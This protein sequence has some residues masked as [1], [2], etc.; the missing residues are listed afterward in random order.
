MEPEIIEGQVVE[1]TKV[2][3]GGALAIAPQQALSIA[4]EPKAVLDEAR[5]AASC[6]MDVMKAK[7]K[8]VVFNGEQYLEYEDWLTVARFY[9]VTAKVV[10]TQFV[11]FG[12]VKGYEARAVALLVSTGMEISGADAMC[13]NDED[14]WSTRKNYKTGEVKPVPMFQLRSMAQTRAC[15]KALR[16]V[17]AWVVVLAG[18]KPT[19]AEEMDG[20]AQT[21][22]EIATPQRKAA[23]QTNAAQ[24]AN[25]AT[26]T[27]SR[28]TGRPVTIKQA[29]R[30]YAIAKG[31]GWNDAEIRQYLSATYG[32][33]ST[34]EITSDVY[35]QVC[36]HFTNG[37]PA[38]SGSVAG[39]QLREPGEDMPE[40]PKDLWD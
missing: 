6:L 24:S 38:G 4:R 22:N 23:P 5:K 34:K 11:D 16:N 33:K 12:G 37:A 25:T 29:N 36:A 15:A 30:A 31:A 13:L 7:T 18:F 17:L 14:N 9:G 10:S 8:K 26:T 19:P 32:F 1:A 3:G 27:P 39:Q 20:L 28:P 35:E 21:Q 2:N 40:E